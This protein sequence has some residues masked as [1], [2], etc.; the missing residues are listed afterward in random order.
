M[1]RISAL[2][3]IQPGVPTRMLRGMCPA[4]LA[5]WIQE[6][7]GCSDVASDGERPGGAC[8]ELS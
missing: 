3:A 1:R 5:A 7:C 6:R 2:E 4:L 8:D